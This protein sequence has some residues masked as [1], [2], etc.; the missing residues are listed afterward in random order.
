MNDP[1]L[2]VPII[3]MLIPIVAIV[4]GVWSR[5]NSERIRADQRMA[6][7]ARG[8]SIAEIDAI[9]KVDEDGSRTK[10]PMRSLGNARRAAT[11][12]I[13][14]G[15]G[16]ILFFVVLE[17]ILQVREIFAGAA[18]GLIPLLIGFGFVVDYQLQKRELSRFGM[19]V[20]ADPRRN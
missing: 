14:I 13:S 17:N 5:A 4:S 16:L 1:G 9:L 3:A 8:H 6:L 15:I 10:D 11:V 2:L 7:L 12:L 18:A 19:E 20:G